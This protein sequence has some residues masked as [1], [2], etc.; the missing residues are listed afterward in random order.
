MHDKAKLLTEL[1]TLKG[2]E[3]APDKSQLGA[4]FY[5]PSP[6]RSEAENQT[7]RRQLNRSQATINQLR[8]EMGGKEGLLNLV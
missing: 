4:T 8:A 2:W 6:M 3:P 5:A 1:Q 7:A